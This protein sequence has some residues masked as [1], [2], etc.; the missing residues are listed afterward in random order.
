MV[1]VARRF[2]ARSRRIV[3]GMTTGRWNSVS[4]R[5]AHS[6]CRPTRAIATGL[7]FKMVCRH[8]RRRHYRHYDFI[9]DG[10]GIIGTARQLAAF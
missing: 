7:G 2:L 6:A 1:E 5:S 10:V 9:I 3:G 4:V 8:A